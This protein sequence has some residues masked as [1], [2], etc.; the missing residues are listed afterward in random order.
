[1]I[2]DIIGAVVIV[3]TARRALLSAPGGAPR[4]PGAIAIL[5]QSSRS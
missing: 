3:L 4:P 2:G 5:F 1:V